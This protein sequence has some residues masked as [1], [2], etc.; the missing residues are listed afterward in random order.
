MDLSQASEWIRLLRRVRSSFPLIIGFVAVIWTVE[1]VNTLMGHQLNVWGIWPRTVTG[2]VGIPLGPF[3]HGSFSHLMS[4]T[5]IFLG[6]GSL[7]AIR[8]RQV[9]MAVSVFIILIGGVGVWAL[10][11]PAIHVGASGLVFGYFGFLVA[12]GWYE[13]RLGSIL[14]AIAVVVL[15]GGLIGGVLPSPG[16]ISWEAHLFGLIAGLLA[17]RNSRK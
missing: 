11:R 16:I 6:L 4:N 5:I 12:V 7:V 14:V 9:L 15:Y 13:R 2:L 3:L 1:L 8:G 17:A 10:G